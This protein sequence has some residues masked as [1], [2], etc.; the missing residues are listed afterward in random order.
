MS[1]T[2][3]VLVDEPF[4]AVLR[5]TLNRP[6]RLNAYCHPLTA[7]RCRAFSPGHKKKHK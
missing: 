5:V 1:E 2:S 3:M 7:E 4:A 6:D